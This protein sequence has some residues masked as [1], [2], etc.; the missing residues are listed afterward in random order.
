MPGCEWLRRG[1]TFFQAGQPHLRGRKGGGKGVLACLE[2]RDGGHFQ[3][4]QRHLRARHGR[5]G[6]GV[7]GCERPSTYE[8]HFQ[9]G[10]KRTCVRA[11][12]ATPAT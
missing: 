11:N 10:Q 2:E 8:T 1:W 6:F 5:E 9:A 7:P 12:T 4:G 3:A